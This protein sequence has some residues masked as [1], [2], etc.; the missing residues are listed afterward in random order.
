ML[1][2]KDSVPIPSPFF[3]ANTGTQSNVE[4]TV[5]HVGSHLLELELLRELLVKL[6]QLGDELTACLDDGGFGG[7]LAVGV[8]AELEG[9]KERMRDLVGG[10][11]DMVH[12]VKLVTEH[13]G[14]GVVF[15]VER[16]QGGVGDLWK[17][18][19]DITVPSCDLDVV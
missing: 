13:V 1:C 14:E 2:T 10:E 15:F 4:S 9:R 11:G 8:N 6:L 12:A 5:R 17:Y 16:E 3:I 19:L 18:V 7:D